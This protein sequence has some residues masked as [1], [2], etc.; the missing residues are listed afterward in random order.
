VAALAPLLAPDCA[1]QDVRDVLIFEPSTPLFSS[2]VACVVNLRA[3]CVGTEP[4]VRPCDYE[5]LE[6]MVSF[7]GVVLVKEFRQPDEA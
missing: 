1:L 2:C 7:R 4:G 6:E 3:F 5:A